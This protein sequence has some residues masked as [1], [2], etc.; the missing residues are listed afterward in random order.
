MLS[1]WVCGC[2]V[3][4]TKDVHP[5]LLPPPYAH[6][7]LP[8][9]YAPP[10]LPPTM[11]P[12]SLPPMHPS[13]Y[14]DHM[15]PPPPQP[16]CTPPSQPICTFSSPSAPSSPAY[17]YP[18]FPWTACY[19]NIDA[20]MLIGTLR[21]CSQVWCS[22]VLVLPGVVLLGAGAPRFGARGCWCSWVLV[23]P[24]VAL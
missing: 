2:L 9:P 12:S 17:M 19:E 6:L 3:V 22:W 15:H 18:S 16:T 20:E 21:W 11:H 14:L 1:V 24:G 4:C 23:L 10:L 5:A 7:H 8:R 13:I